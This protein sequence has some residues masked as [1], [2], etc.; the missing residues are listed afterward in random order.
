MCQEN[1]IFTKLII[2]IIIIIIHGLGRLICS[3]IDALTSFPRAS[4][5]SSSSMFVVEGVFR[6]SD[7]VHNFNMVD[8]IC[9]W[10]SRLVFQRS[11]VH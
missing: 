5:I 7:V 10:I 8:P 4:M 11:L 6:E 9:A 3:G 1:L 2:I